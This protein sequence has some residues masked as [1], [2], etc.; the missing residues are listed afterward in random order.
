MS[1]RIETTCVQG[2]YHPGVVGRE[3]T[4]ERAVAQ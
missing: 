2:G 4:F 1:N 3:Y